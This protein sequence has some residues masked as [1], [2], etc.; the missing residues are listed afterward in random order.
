MYVAKFGNKI[1]VLHVFTKKTQKTPKPDIDLAKKRY[2]EAK[3]NG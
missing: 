1:N 2:K 3:E